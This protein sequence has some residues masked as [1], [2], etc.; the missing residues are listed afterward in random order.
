MAFIQ[1]HKLFTYFSEEFK[2]KKSS[3]NWQVF[4]CPFCNDLSGSKKMAVHFHYGVV[5]CWVCQYKETVVDFVSEYE[6]LTYNEARDFLRDVKASV[7]D[8]ARI[9]EEDTEVK[10]LET[11]NLPYGFT[12]LLEGETSMGDRARKVLKDRGF[13]LKEL[14]RM[15]FGYCAE[16]AT[17]EM[18]SN[19]DYFGYI[20]IP[21][22]SQGKLVYYIGRDFIG[23]YLR[24]KNPN[25]E[26]VGIG[27]EQVMFN[28]DAL[29][30]YGEVFVLEGWA[31]AATIG[32]QAVATLGAKWS[33]N[34][35]SKI[36]SSE[37]ERIVIVPDAGVD[38]SGKRF[39]VDALEK[40]LG[41]IDHKEVIVVDMDELEGKDV[42]AVGL[43]AFREQ[44]D[45]SPVLTASKIVEL[46]F[47]A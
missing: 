3:Q 2:L 35:M 45:K 28:E 8:F 10:V 7:I 29:R 5:K 15:G 16:A 43:A 33:S 18:E 9:E 39:Y 4:E 6:G 20:I 44:Y 25:K 41:L 47:E 1:P 42:N 31:D 23:N 46:I 37:A 24:Y 13:D 21:I 27:K 11:I 26:T 14:D 30:I 40:A 17:E 34:Q 32:R 12:P 22:K 38:G 19:E 36:I